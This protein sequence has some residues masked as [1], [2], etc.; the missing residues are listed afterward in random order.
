MEKRHSMD[1]EK[2]P[3]RDIQNQGGKD[4]GQEDREREE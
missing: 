2:L 4:K 1:R 3:Q